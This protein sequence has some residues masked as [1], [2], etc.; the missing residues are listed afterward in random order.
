[1]GSILA[2]DYGLKRI[3]LAISDENRLF[4]FPYSTIE[5]KNNETVINRIKEIILEKE[6]DLILI[7]IS[8]YK[9]EVHGKISMEDI[10]TNFTNKLKK[11]IN[12]KVDII[13]ERFSTFA[14]NENLKEA[15]ISAKEAKKY[16]DQE[17]A[18]LLLEEYISKINKT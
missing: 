13:D 12:I 15:G 14:A 3:G 6:I 16:I 10:V 11:S 4:A 7:G 1:M 5:N 17:A 2:I 9:K 8:Y 18:R